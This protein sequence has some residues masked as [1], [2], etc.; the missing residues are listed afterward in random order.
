MKIHKTPLV[1]LLLL[2]ASAL[3]PLSGC[4]DDPKEARSPA[5]DWGLP[6]DVP[7][8]KV[9]ADNPMTPEKVELGR[10]LFYDT[11][12]SGNETFSC[13]S[14][15]KQELGFADELA[16]AEGSTGQI[17]PRSSM[18]L[19]NVAYNSTYGWGNPLLTT[20]E[21]QAPIPMF[22]EEPVE[23]G[24]AGKEE[25][26]IARLSA[27][28]L[29]QDLFAAAFPD[30][31]APF[32]RERIIDNI[33]KAIASFE[34]TLI[35]YNSPFDLWIRGE[36]QVPDAVVRGWILFNSE[37]FECFHCHGGFSFTDASTHEGKV[38]DEIS[39]HNTGLYNLGEDGA[40]PPE[41][42]G[43][44]EI[45]N[46]PNDMGRFKA[47]TLRNIAVTAPYMHDG[48]IATLD[49]VLD[50]YA[51]G[52]RTIEEGDKAGVGSDNPIKS[53][54]VD[55]FVFTGSKRADLLA[56]LNALTDE[57]FLND[58]RFSDP[59]KEGETGGAEDAGDE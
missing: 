37:E 35:S 9:P 19:T 46:N 1:A 27:D 50:H 45:S 36:A 29:Y 39:F 22:G 4:G 7:I 30:D 13:G 24:L 55:G 41:N 3:I 14:C 52:G 49:E 23:L 16:R 44:F 17:H 48:S 34:R 5:Y 31:P 21:K 57:T 6:K 10:Y 42:T 28:P 32:A 2:C 26:I 8:P 18:G 59:F 47:P 20:L 58:P 51:A 15:H 43:V 53:Q 11:R 54:F 33:V 12:L 56:F 40:Y 25:D 38:F